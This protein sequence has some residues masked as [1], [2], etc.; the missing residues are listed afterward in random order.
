MAELSE[1]PE[2]F[3]RFQKFIIVAHR[4]QTG[5]GNSS[6]EPDV[7]SCGGRLESLTRIR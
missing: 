6:V 2:V 1:F 5:G 4:K 3:F 7:D